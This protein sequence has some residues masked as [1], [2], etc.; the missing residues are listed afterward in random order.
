MISNFLNNFLI[1]NWRINP[2]FKAFTDIYVED[3]NVNVRK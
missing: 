1:P 3:L 2:C